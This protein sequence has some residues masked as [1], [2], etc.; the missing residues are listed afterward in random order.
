MLVPR[1]VPNSHHRPRF[2][3][4]ERPHITPGCYFEMKDENQAQLRIWI[5]AIPPGFQKNAD[6]V[7]RRQRHY[8]Q[9]SLPIETR[10]AALNEGQEILQKRVIRQCALEV[11]APFTWDEFGCYSRTVHT[12]IW[13]SLDSISLLQR[14]PTCVSSVLPRPRVL[15]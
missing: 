2:C 12:E 8:E 15:G 14:H 10:A 7:S 13:M 9:T 11:K 4:V 5:V 1:E 6:R 3:S